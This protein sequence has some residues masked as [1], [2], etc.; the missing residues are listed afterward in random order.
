M[1]YTVVKTVKTTDLRE[2]PYTYTTYKRHGDDWGG[3]CLE[4]VFTT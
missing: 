2:W 3:G 4:M 1:G